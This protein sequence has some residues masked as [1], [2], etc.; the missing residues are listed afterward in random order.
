MTCHF[1]GQDSATFTGYA[2]ARLLCASSAGVPCP[3][4][5][6]YAWGTARA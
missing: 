4:R 6:E 3:G 2:A 5:S 1:W